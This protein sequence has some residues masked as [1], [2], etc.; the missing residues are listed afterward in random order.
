M[1]I[2]RSLAVLLLLSVAAALAVYSA[3]QPVELS[4]FYAT[5]AVARAGAPITFTFLFRVPMDVS[6]NPKVYFK[7]PGNKILMLRAY[8]VDDF[9]CTISHSLPCG[10]DAE[11]AEITLVGTKTAENKRVSAIRSFVKFAPLEQRYSKAPRNLIAGEWI[12][13]VSELEKSKRIE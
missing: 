13:K 3:D 6:E 12:C 8:W 7:I 4:M 2:I 11:S 10:I 5:P 9:T 1:K